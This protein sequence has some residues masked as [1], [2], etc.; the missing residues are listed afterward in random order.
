M[1]FDD[2]LR[3]AFP[4]ETELFSLVLACSAAD[5]TTGESLPVSRVRPDGSTIATLQLIVYELI[6]GKREVRDIKEQDVVFLKAKHRSDPRIDAYITGWREALLAV[7]E[8]QE[9][10]L[11]RDRAAYDKLKHS[12]AVLMPHDLG[13]P[14]LL[15]LRRPRDAASFT[16]ALLS[17]KRFGQLLA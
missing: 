2:S 11:K 8:S 12:I 10:L 15:D 9:A 14:E 3:A 6:G 7:F 4:I 13:K 17:T 1:S 5:Y 16:D